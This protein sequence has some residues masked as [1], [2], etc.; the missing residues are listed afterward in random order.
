MS[1]HYL[2]DCFRLTG[3]DEID[4][5]QT[6]Q[7]NAVID[8]RPFLGFFKR[9]VKIPY[10]LIG[11]PVLVFVVIDANLQFTKNRKT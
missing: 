9:C 6:K 10:V 4:A 5:T 1:V 2:D 3:S 8:V 11:K 7:F